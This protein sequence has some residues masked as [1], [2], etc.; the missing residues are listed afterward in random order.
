M[1]KIMTI[2]ISLI[3]SV[4][5]SSI[6]MIQPAEVSAASTTTTLF[7]CFEKSDGAKVSKDGT[8][9][10]YKGITYDLNGG[11]AKWDSEDECY[12][13]YHNSGDENMYEI[14]WNTKPDG[15]GTFYEEEAT[16]STSVKTLYAVW[17]YE[18]DEDD[19]DE[20][21]D[22]DD[23]NLDDDEDLDDEEDDEDLD[24]E[25]LNDDSD[26]E[27]EDIDDEDDEDIDEDGDQNF[28]D[29]EDIDEDQ[30]QDFEDDENV[31]NE[32][33]EVIEEEPEEELF[34]IPDVCG[35]I[36]AEHRVS[37]NYETMDLFEVNGIKFELNGGACVPD[38]DTYEL[39]PPLGIVGMAGDS[40]FVHWNTKADDSGNIY[41]PGEMVKRSEIEAVAPLY[42]IWTD[43][44]LDSDE[45]NGY[46]GW[47]DDSETTE[48]EKPAEDIGDQN[49]NDSND[50][51]LDE[52]EDSDINDE[53]DE[54]FEDDEDIYE[55]EDSDVDDKDDE[56]FEDDEDEDSNADHEDLDEDDDSDDDEEKLDI[57]GDDDPQQ[58]ARGS[59]EKSDD[60]NEDTVEPVIDENPVIDVKPVKDTTITRIF[61]KP[62]VDARHFSYN[63]TEQI[64]SVS[65]YNVY[66]YDSEDSSGHCGVLYWTDY[67][68]I[69]AIIFAA[70]LMII[71]GI[72]LLVRRHT[73]F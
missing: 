26:D 18:D 30:D 11:Y 10:T 59:G 42:A 12:Y 70:V 47:D 68:E 39:L 67:M 51:D 2:V 71:S 61:Q 22:D 49:E 72:I 15:S 63:P 9:I 17:E 45:D 69:I 6:A 14:G 41:E 57:D 44:G 24:D 34:E 29:D 60:S 55:D 7:E 31:D 66:Y 20:D 36:D 58:P 25:D 4:A 21:L 5:F 13:F 43:S 46:V 48:P 62:A 64:D 19:D 35:N 40:E 50:E 38:G 8:I 28:E 52:N 54:N 33:D 56:N 53:D 65:E 37:A 1:K 3:L 16:V 73:Q 23:E 27:D 32:D